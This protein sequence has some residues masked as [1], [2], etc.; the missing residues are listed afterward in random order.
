MEIQARKIS[1]TAPCPCGS[2]KTYEDCCEKRG[3]EFARF[4]FDDREVVFDVEA[5]D[6]AVQDLM[7][8][9]SDEIYKPFNDGASLDIQSALEKLY[10]NF[11]KFEKSLSSFSQ[12]SSCQRGCTA[13]CHHIVETP[14]IEAEAVRRVVEKR[15]SSP[16]K[17]SLKSKISQLSHAYPP[18]LELDEEYDEDLQ[19]NHFEKHIPCPFLSAQGACM[20][21]DARPL[22]CR[23]YM[24]FSDPK[25]CAI[26]DGMAV[27]EADYFPEVHRASQVLSLMVFKDIRLRRHLPDWF[28]HEFQV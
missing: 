8:F 3:V 14:A 2:D 20:V 17:A 13:C 16:A 15:F 1:R 9:L 5:T 23:T 26:G 10:D 19:E 18:A 12:A 24:V 28:I 11:G 21:Y 25:Q 7:A 27:Y 6:N 22:V 4:Q